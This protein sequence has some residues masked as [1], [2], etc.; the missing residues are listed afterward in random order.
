MEPLRAGLTS[1]EASHLKDLALPKQAIMPTSPCKILVKSV[2]I[3][4]CNS[5]YHF[6]AFLC[7]IILHYTEGVYAFL[8][9]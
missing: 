2:C 9:F 4:L 1:R 5:L 6:A 7:T 3:F 8:S